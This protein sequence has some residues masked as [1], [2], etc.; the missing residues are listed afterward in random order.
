VKDRKARGMLPTSV[1]QDRTEFWS[2]TP[3]VTGLRSTRASDMPSKPA[4]GRELA[5]GFDSRP[6]P[7]RDSGSDHHRSRAGPQIGPEETGSAGRKYR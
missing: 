2:L 1:N 6:P 5:G 7:L 4:C 3:L